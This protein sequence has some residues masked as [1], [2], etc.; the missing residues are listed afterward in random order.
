MSRRERGK[1]TVKMQ[2]LVRPCTSCRTDDPAENSKAVDEARQ[3]PSH[4]PKASTA[5]QYLGENLLPSSAAL[6]L[7]RGRGTVPRANRNPVPL[8]ADR[9]RVRGCE[10]TGRAA[11]P[12][13]CQ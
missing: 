11:E 1:V 5:R 2:Q 13:P 3:S 8:R 10:F 9:C 6:G 4:L 7:A 12:R